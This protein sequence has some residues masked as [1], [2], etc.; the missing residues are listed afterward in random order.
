MPTSIPTAAATLPPATSI[1]HR[2]LLR[3]RVTCAPD[4]Q[5]GAHFSSPTDVSAGISG[6]SAETTYHYRVVVA[7]ADGTKYGADRTYTPHKVVGLR[8][9]DPRRRDRLRRATLNGSFV[10]D[11]THTTYYFEWGRRP[12]TA[13]AAAPQA[14]TPAR[15]RAR[16]APPSRLRPDRPRI[17]TT[18]Y[19][20]R[21]VA[22]SAAGTDHRRGPTV[23]DP[24]GVPDGQQGAA[25]TAVHS[26]RA[27]IHGEVDPNGADTDRSTSSTSTTRPSSR[28]AVGRD[29]ATPRDRVRDGQGVRSR[30]PSL[31]GLSP[32]NPLPLQG[33]GTNFSG[34]RQPDA[35]T[36]STFAFIPSFSRPLPQRPRAPADRRRPA[37]RLPRL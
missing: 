36:F 20:Y 28:A 14:L 4:P 34:Q 13:T 22:T 12:P 1:R 18:T 31:N 24:A 21:V 6:L 11:G 32:G 35:A 23:H 33:C 7:N 10:G 17:P 9:D 27:I 37:A 2:R 29:A 3:H 16:L 26:D 25:V 5:P 8:T 15:R 30:Q 19:H